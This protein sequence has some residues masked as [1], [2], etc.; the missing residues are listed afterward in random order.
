MTSRDDLS[1]GYTDDQLDAV[2]RFA[3]RDRVVGAAPPPGAWWRIKAQAQE[4]TALWRFG[5][6]GALSL[7]M[8]VVTAFQSRLDGLLPTL[9]ASIVRIGN[10]PPAGC[11]LPRTWMS[12]HRI[13]MRL[14]C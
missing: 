3:L 1:R 2:I 12:Q 4:L 14:V 7:P 10:H 5:M 13:V 6:A 8:R 11:D 9:E